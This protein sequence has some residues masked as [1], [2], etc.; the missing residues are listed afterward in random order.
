MWP[1]PLNRLL[2]LQMGY[3]FMGIMYS[4]GSSP[5]PAG[6]RTTACGIARRCTALEEF[7]VNNPDT[8]YWNS[9]ADCKSRTSRSQPTTKPPAAPE[10]NPAHPNS[11]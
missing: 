3:C 10:S 1:L 7:G 6:P 9:D 5:I 11:R 4:G 8:P 2:M